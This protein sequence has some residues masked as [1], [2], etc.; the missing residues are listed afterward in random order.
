[1][2]Q[3][4]IYILL[5]LFVFYHFYNDILK[6]LNTGNLL[7]GFTRAEDSIITKERTS[8]CKPGCTESLYDFGNCVDVEIDGELYRECPY[9]CMSGNMNDEN[10]CLND[11]DCD[12]EK[13]GKVALKKNRYG[14][15]KSLLN[16]IR[17]APLDIKNYFAPRWFGMAPK[18]GDETW[19][20][21]GGDDYI[22]KKI[23]N[24]TGS[25][26]WS[27]RLLGTNGSNYVGKQNTTNTG[28]SCLK[29]NNQNVNNIVQGL[30]YSNGTALSNDEKNDIKRMDHNFCRNPTRDSSG[31]WCVVNNDNGIL[32]KEYCNPISLEKQ[33]IPSGDY[34]NLG[35]DFLQRLIDVR[36]YHVSFTI[37]DS[38]YKKVGQAV[39]EAHKGKNSDGQLS[40]QKLNHMLQEIE[41]SINEDASRFLGSSPENTP[42]NTQNDQGTNIDSNANQRS[43]LN[44]GGGWGGPVRFSSQG[45]DCSNCVC[46][47]INTIAD[48]LQVM[49]HSTDEYQTMR[50][51]NQARTDNRNGGSDNLLSQSNIESNLLNANFPTNAP[52]LDATYQ[53]SIFPKRPYNS[54]WDMY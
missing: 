2:Y 53:S 20:H 46:N 29:W 36:N 27:E 25:N 21:N 31:I 35:K 3:Y 26:W 17:L 13:C 41:D 40:N 34:I 24:W 50:Q 16:Q 7:E 23:N 10:K 9:K 14:W 5:A 51:L 28:K 47:L 18:E 33:T 38:T 44:S 45:G 42:T 15:A 48:G 52:Q 8:E 49:L 11:R 32:A 37:S 39:F 1:M 12:I 19:L 54:V 43:I 6:Y 30:S 4:I 22:N